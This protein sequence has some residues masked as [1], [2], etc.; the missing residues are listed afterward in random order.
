[1]Q[2]DRSWLRLMRP[3]Y[4]HAAHMHIR[5]RCPPDQRDCIQ[6]APPPP[7][8]ACDATLQWWFDQLGVPPSKPGP[9]HRPPPLP[10]ACKAVISDQ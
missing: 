8:D 5:F 4:G 6:A 10:A 7:G 3:W 9:P 1:V 2:G